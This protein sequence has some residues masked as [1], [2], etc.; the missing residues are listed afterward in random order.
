MRPACQV[1]LRAEQHDEGE[2]H[3]DEVLEHVLRRSQ[4]SAQ[5]LGA[6]KL[7]PRAR[8]GQFLSNVVV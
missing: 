6:P 2:G 7:Q 1:L 5:G 8:Q 4:L 3:L